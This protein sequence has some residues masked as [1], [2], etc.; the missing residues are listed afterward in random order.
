MQPLKIEARF[1]RPLNFADFDKKSMRKGFTQVGRDVS[2]IAKKLVSKKG[3]S[4]AGAYPGK[5]TGIF[6]KAISYKVSRSGFSVAVKP[7]GKGKRVSAELKDA[8]FIPRLSSLATQGPNAASEPV[9]T[10]NN[11]LRQKWPSRV[12]IRSLL[13]L[14]PMAEPAFNR[15][16][17]RF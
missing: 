11:P 16:W 15:S 6:Q 9:R 7:Y 4:A 10:A 3:V 13:P 5:Q 14:K 17:G 2:K 8:G 12:P 1:A